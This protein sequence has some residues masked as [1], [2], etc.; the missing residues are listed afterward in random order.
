MKTK[1]IV[2]YYLYELKNSILV[3]YLIMFIGC[4][5][6]YIGYKLSDGNLYSTG[7]ELATII[8]IFV[9]GLNLFKSQFL[10]LIQNGVTR[11]ANFIGFVACTPIVVVFAIIDSFVSVIMH[12]LIGYESIFN[13]LYAS[14]IHGYGFVYILNSILFLTVVYGLFLMLGYFITTLYYAM[15]KAM[16]IIVSVG[17]PVFVFIILPI[18]GYFLNIDIEAGIENIIL[19][20]LG[21]NGSNNVSILYPIISC[22]ITYTILSLLTYIIARR[23][24]VK[25]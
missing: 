14:S 6:T 13:T 3:F 7:I 8:F 10:F 19:N 21:V 5:A 9:L 25:E 4:V 23:V 15:N 2:K 22:A 24:A 17:V 16:K 12:N 11:K 1:A 20:M 18:I